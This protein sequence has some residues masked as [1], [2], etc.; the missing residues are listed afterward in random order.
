MRVCVYNSFSDHISVEMQGFC[1]CT[2]ISS[3]TIFKKEFYFA[4]SA[5]I[6]KSVCEISSALKI[7]KRNILPAFISPKYFCFKILIKIK[8]F[9]FLKIPYIERDA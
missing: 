7:S 6:I 9:E 4:G 2:M 5:L 8:Q 1:F 3:A